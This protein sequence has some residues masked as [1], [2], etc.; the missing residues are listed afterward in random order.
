MDV[1]GYTNDFMAKYMKAESV[2]GWL[3]Y[4]SGLMISSKGT[5]KFAITAGSLYVGVGRYVTPALDTSVAGTF[6]YYYQ[7]VSG[8]TAVAASTQINITQ[9]DNGTG[10][11][12]TGA[13]NK[14]YVHSVYARINSPTEFAVLMPQ[15]EYNSLAEAQAVAGAPANVPAFGDAYSTGRFI[16]SI[17]TKYNTVAFADILSPFTE[18]LTSATP[19]THNNLSGLQGGT[20]D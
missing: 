2:T 4:G 3:S 8:W 18:A 13:V 12:A 5:Q 17:I 7:A 6:T 10:T 16:G 19:T 1:S 11:L 15:A 9:W 14:Y 20:V